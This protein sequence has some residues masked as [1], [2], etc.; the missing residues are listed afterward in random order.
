MSKQISPKELRTIKLQRDE[1][2]LEHLR[3]RLIMAPDAV[4][5]R[6]IELAI[7]ET[8]TRMAR[9]NSPETQEALDA[10]QADHE[11]RQQGDMAH[12][13]EEAQILAQREL[14][15]SEAYQRKI[16]EYGVAF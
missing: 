7:K 10:W 12:A 9:E 13:A 6:S 1:R 3:N 4:T 8:E 2:Q 11:R 16:G 15:Q 5:R 14:R